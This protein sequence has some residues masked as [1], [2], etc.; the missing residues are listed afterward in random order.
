MGKGGYPRRKAS[1][2]SHLG[3]QKNLFV[4]YWKA[5]NY[6]RGSGQRQGRE[7]MQELHAPWK[8]TL[9]YRTKVI[10]HSMTQPGGIY[11]KHLLGSF[12]IPDTRGAGNS[13]VNKTGSVLDL[14]R[15]CFSS[16]SQ[17]SRRLHQTGSTIVSRK[18]G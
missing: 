12:N 13:T 11:V 17:L 8:I 16:R 6:S 14:Q 3:Y 1:P 10:F 15:F 4:T 5:F 9:P 2:P 18:K 7:S